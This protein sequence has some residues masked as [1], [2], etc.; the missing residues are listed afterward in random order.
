MAMLNIIKG[1]LKNIVDEAQFE[2]LYKPNGWRI[3]E[4]ENPPESEES[5]ALKIL[6]TEQEFKNYV[7]MSKTKPKQFDDKL[8]YSE[9]ENEI[10]S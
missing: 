10:R 5:K 6:H 1:S 2:R 7:K 8:F 4:T 9:T 3:D